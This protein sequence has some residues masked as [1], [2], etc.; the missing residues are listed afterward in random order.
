MTQKNMG[1]F[2]LGL[3]T[4]RQ[5]QTTRVQGVSIRDVRTGDNVST[6]M[7]ETGEDVS[8]TN[9]RMVDDVS[10]ADMRMMNMGTLRTRA[11]RT[12]TKGL[13]SNAARVHLRTV[14]VY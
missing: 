2:I 14:L 1:Q 10:M 4:M 7:M 9:V 12:K 3:T 8:T 11:M 6:T 13:D 5:N